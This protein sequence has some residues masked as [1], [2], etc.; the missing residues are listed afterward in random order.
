MVR[1]VVPLETAWNVVAPELPVTATGLA[2]VPT[3]VSELVIGT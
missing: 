1:F 2:M 3:V